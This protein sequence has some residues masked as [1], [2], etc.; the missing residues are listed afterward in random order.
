MAILK[1]G[2]SIKC[3]S[4]EEIEVFKQ[5]A[6][7]EGHFWSSGDPLS[8]THES[9]RGNNLSFQVGYGDRYF[10]DDISVA[11]IDF[12]NGN[13][14]SVEASDLFRNQLISRRVKRER[15]SAK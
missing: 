6:A 13:T 5:V 15:N 10:P 4:R 11:S 7:A 2:M 14:V 12:G 1:K 3:R 8:Q 9:H